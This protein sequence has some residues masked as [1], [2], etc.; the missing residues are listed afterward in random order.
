MHGL[1]DQT[2]IVSTISSGGELV[3]MIC[4][5]VQRQSDNKHKIETI[6]SLDPTVPLIFSSMENYR[7]IQPTDAV[8]GD[9][10]SPNSRGVPISGGQVVASSSGGELVGIIFDEMQHQLDNKP[11]IE[12]FTSLDAAA[13]LIFSPMEN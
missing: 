8:F 12:T 9:I 11:K 6:I 3:S 13:P 5:E 4:D 10:S 1:S 2:Y 7:N